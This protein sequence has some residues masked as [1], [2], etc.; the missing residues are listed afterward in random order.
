MLSELAPPS[1]PSSK[2]PQRQPSKTPP[3]LVAPRVVVRVRPLAAEGGHS[4]HG[5]RVFKR[6]AK[7]D[8]GAIV[9]DDN[10]DLHR[11]GEDNNNPQRPNT[12]PPGKNSRNSPPALEA[13]KMNPDCSAAG[14]NPRGSPA[15]STVVVS[16]STRAGGSN[17]QFAIR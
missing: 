9:L 1:G 5:K 7:W 14:H 17:W 10:V 15:R 11:L 8:E 12:S 13:M 4:T 2:T 6:L 3:P 16:S